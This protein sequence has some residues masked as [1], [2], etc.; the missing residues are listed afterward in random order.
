MMLD[1]G[2]WQCCYGRRAASRMAGLGVSFFLSMW[3]LQPSAMRLVSLECWAA[4]AQQLVTAASQ[5]VL[6]WRQLIVMAGCLRCKQTACS[7]HRSISDVCCLFHVPVLPPFP[8]AA[9]HVACHCQMSSSKWSHSGGRL[10]VLVACACAAAAGGGVT[11]HP[12]AS[13]GHRGWS[14]TGCVEPGATV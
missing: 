3:L 6:D 14:H 10:R 13:E 8:T 9:L 1:G 11:Q 7:G 2:G 4:S 12:G 5:A